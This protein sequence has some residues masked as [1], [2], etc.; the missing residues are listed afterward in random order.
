MCATQRGELRRGT[1]GR[2]S[3][4][5]RVGHVGFNRAHW[6]LGPSRSPSAG[7]NGY[8]V[9]SQQRSSQGDMWWPFGGRAR[10][11]GLAHTPAQW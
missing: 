2:G 3:P 9:L 5:G 10:Q 11:G 1:Q 4:V 6:V 8:L 7:C